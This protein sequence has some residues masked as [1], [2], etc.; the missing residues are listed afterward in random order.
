MKLALQDVDFADGDD[1]AVIR[2]L[3]VA[4]DQLDKAFHPNVSYEDG[5]AASKA[6]WLSLYGFQPFYHQKVVDLDTGKTVAFSRWM[7]EEPQ[8]PFLPPR[9]GKFY[10]ESA[11]RLVL[12]TRNRHSRGHRNSG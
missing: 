1:L 2:A 11:E 4:D 12:I 5:V 3:A 8:F 6:R 10:A 9:T 7:V